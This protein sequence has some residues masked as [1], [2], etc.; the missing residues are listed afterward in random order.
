MAR[1]LAPSEPSSDGKTQ[2]GRPGPG[3]AQNA[4]PAAPN[5]A[6]IESVRGSVELERNT[7]WRMAVWALRVGYGGLAIALLGVLAL[8]LGATPWV[9]AAGVFVWLA[10]A[11]TTLTG[12]FRARSELPQPRPGYWALRLALIYDTVHARGSS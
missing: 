10:A 6:K 11:A 3:P 1:R 9:L 5:R 7:H 8:S 2:R 12:V 4:L